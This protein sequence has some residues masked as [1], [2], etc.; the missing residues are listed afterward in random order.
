MSDPSLS[1][2]ADWAAIVYGQYDAV[3]VPYHPGIPE[4]AQRGYVGPDWPPPVAIGG[5]S[6]NI[7]PAPPIWRTSGDYHQSHIEIALG[8]AEPDSPTWLSAA[9]LRA[10]CLQKGRYGSRRGIVRLS[11][12]DAVQVPDV[13][14]FDGVELSAMQFAEEAFASGVPIANP[15]FQTKE[16]IG[17]PGDGYWPTFIPNSPLADLYPWQRALG[18]RNSPVELIGRLSEAGV[19]TVDFRSLPILAAARSLSVRE[20]PLWVVYV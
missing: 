18:A 7:G 14:D 12:L 6:T 15:H 2:P 8:R 4:Y 1:A 10:E 20:L 9:H 11:Y 3:Q 19:L 17:A 16:P 5:A 13:D